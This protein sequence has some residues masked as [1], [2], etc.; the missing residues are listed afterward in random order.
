MDMD[1]NIKNKLSKPALV[2]CVI[3]FYNSN[4]YLAETLQSLDDQDRFIEVLIIVDHG[5]DY[6]I[7]NGSYKNLKIS[8]YF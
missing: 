3:P 1:N 5:S 6:P 4:Q 2:T 7:V 8:I